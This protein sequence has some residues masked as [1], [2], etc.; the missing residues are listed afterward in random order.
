M[1][2][3][4]NNTLLNNKISTFLFKFYN[5]ILGIN[6]R[7]A[8]FNNETDPSCT[9]CNA[10]KFFPVERESF[11]HL[12]YYCPTTNKLLSSFLERFFT[13]NSLMCIEYFSSIINYKEDDNKALQLALDIF[14]YYIW[15]CKLEEKNTNYREHL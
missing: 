7:V 3:S 14:R 4:W 12:F 1:I 15:N 5:N 11:A 10:N 6:S 13:I 2:S 9:F 8:K